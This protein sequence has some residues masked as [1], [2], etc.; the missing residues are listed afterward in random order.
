MEQKPLLRKRPS[1]VEGPI[2]FT[3]KRREKRASP[4]PMIQKKSASKTAPNAPLKLRIRSRLNEKESKLMDKLEEDYPEVGV[5]DID[6][7]DNQK[8]MIGDD[9]PGTLPNSAN[10][11]SRKVGQIGGKKIR[12]KSRKGGRKKRKTQKRSNRTK[13]RSHSRTQQRKRRR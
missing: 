4:K 8:W 3:P 1:I 10:S 9:G 13:S 12:R 7:W 11:V 5:V 2:D 6:Q